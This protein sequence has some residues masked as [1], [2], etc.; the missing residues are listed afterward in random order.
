MGCPS[1]QREQTVNLPA[2]A[3]GGSNPPLSTFV[4]WRLSHQQAAIWRQRDD[5]LVIGASVGTRP[6]ARLFDYTGSRL[7]DLEV[8]SAGVQ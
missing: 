1:G 7:L 8:L 5:P 2:N 4:S 6:G 3:Y